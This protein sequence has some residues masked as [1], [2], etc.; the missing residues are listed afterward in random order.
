M[1]P[2]IM[3]TKAVTIRTT[4]FPI[5]RYA[6]RNEQSVQRS[7]RDGR[8]WSPLRLD[9]GQK[10]GSQKA[11]VWVGRAP[12]TAQEGERRSDELRGALAEDRSVSAVWDYPEVRFRNRF[13][14]LE[15]QRHVIEGIAIAEDDQRFGG[16]RRQMR[17]REIHVVV[18]VGKPVNH[19]E[20]L[21]N[22]RVA[23]LVA[24]AHPRHFGGADHRFRKLPL[25]GPAA[26]REVRRCAD[27]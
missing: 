16:N 17:R 24:R 4:S 27:D 8:P 19:L 1:S 21:T 23:A 5:Q 2:P 13:I 15:R 18:G 9:S 26:A 14:Q 3:S 6:F 11:L 12:L 25:R 22:L 10:R 7:V 20:Q